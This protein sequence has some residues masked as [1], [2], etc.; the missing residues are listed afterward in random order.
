[1]KKLIFILFTY[2]LIT[3]CATSPSTLIPQSFT[4]NS[5]NGMLVG[6][7]AIE[8]KKPIFNQYFFHYLGELD[9]SISTNRMITIRPEQMTSMKFKPDFFD[10]NK[11]VYYFL[12]TEVQ[13]KYKF[14]TLRLHENGGYIQS[15]GEIPMN[16]TF[17]IEK[18]KVKYLGEIY[19]NYANNAV[20]LYNKKERDIPKFKEKYP[21][22]IIEQ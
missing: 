8:N 6:T 4:A 18:G 1:M 3:S 2:L 21:N 17:H 19:F 15:Q 16:I 7:I 5:N 9:K 11:A 10:E 13:G 12:I 22:L 20:R 14:T